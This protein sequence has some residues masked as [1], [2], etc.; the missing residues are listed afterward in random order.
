MN[1]P[2]ELRQRKGRQGARES[3]THPHVQSRLSVWVPATFT[4]ACHRTR[5]FFIKDQPPKYI[6]A[7]PWRRQPCVV[8]SH[9]PCP[10]DPG[11]FN[12]NPVVLP[13]SILL[14]EFSDSSSDMSGFRR[15]KAGPVARRAV[16][17]SW[18]DRGLAA[19][20]TDDV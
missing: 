10:N 13:N 14:L 6:L 12:M 4:P 1:R 5:R 20:S 9:G 2:T 11:L 17:S 16:L 19:E 15:C 8:I 18:L 7:C 3:I